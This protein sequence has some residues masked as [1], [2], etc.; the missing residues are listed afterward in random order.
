MPALAKTQPD[1]T[2][3]VE[4]LADEFRV[5][6][7]EVAAGYERERAMLETAAVV[8]KFVPIFAIRK[9]RENLQQRALGSVEAAT[10]PRPKFAVVGSASAHD[11]AS[12][13]KAVNVLAPR[14]APLNLRAVR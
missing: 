13:A 5:P 12:P 10:E 9:V 7:A 2:R 11:T 14:E 4:I 6:V 3:S 1:Q 8:T